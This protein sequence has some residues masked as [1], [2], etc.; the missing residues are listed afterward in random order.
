MEEGSL[1]ARLNDE[2]HD[3]YALVDRECLGE[4][5]KVH[6]RDKLG[7]AGDL[8]KERLGGNRDELVHLQSAA[9]KR[10]AVKRRCVGK[11]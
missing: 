7:A 1:A 9:P 4:G 11:L 3:V 2:H 6:D 10:N 8:L 5:L